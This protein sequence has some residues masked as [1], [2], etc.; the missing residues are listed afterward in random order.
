MG[1]LVGV[2]V[3]PIVAV[4]PRVAVAVAVGEVEAV[5]VDDLPLPVLAAA[6][7]AAHTTHDA[8]SMAHIG[9]ATRRVIK[10]RSD[11]LSV[12]GCG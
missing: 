4:G 11:W 8:T 9:M 7:T 10:A 12:E 5:L 6:L 1:G 3:G 2:A